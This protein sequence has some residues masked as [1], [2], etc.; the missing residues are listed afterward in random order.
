MQ[1]FLAFEN[2]HLRVIHRPDALHGKAALW[3]ELEKRA[4]AAR[5]ISS[6]HFDNDPAFT[7]KQ[8]VIRGLSFTGGHESLATRR[9]ALFFEAAGAEP[10]MSLRFYGASML[11]P[12]LRAEIFDRAATRLYLLHSQERLAKALSRRRG[13]KKRGFRL[14][15][16]PTPEGLDVFARD[17]ALP[18]VRFTSRVRPV[19]DLVGARRALLAL[20][21]EPST[22]I[23]EPAA[24]AHAQ[25]TDPAA[26]G[27]ARI[28]RLDPERIEIDVT[29]SGSGY[30]VLADTFY[31]GWQAT[32]D[33]LSAP[34]H[35]A[36]L[37]LRAV[38]VPAGDSRVVFA[39]QPRSFA[40]GLAV[41][42]GAWLLLAGLAVRAGLGRRP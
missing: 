20:V 37:L 32:V 33:G 4:G 3:G 40:L 13:A 29:A 12:T 7:A 16:M 28:L 26:T 27:T 23:L 25:R 24:G 38:A 36:D 6:G 8:A 30:L 10:F 42:G 35:P 15:E 31:P 19:E 17:G 14:L 22:T 11:P 21:D 5:L 34:I 9:H 1:L 18:R 41:G 2:R 39:Y